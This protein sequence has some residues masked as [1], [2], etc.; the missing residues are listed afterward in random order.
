MEL[1]DLENYIEKLCKEVLKFTHK[2]YMPFE[3]CIM[4]NQILNTNI[5]KSLDLLWK[6][7]FSIVKSQF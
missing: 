1:Q 7:T 6:L 4:F 2:K 5:R 3:I